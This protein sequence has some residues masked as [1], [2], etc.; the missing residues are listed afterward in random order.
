MSRARGKQTKNCLSGTAEQVTFENFRKGM[1]YHEFGRPGWIG[2]FNFRI[3]GYNETR[4]WK[5][6][7]GARG[8]K[9]PR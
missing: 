8:V 5:F 1:I 7:A 6:A 4:V 2:K 9:A 3:K